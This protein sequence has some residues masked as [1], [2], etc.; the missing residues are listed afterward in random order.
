VGARFRRFGK[1]ALRVTCLVG[2]LGLTGFA[3]LASAHAAG[4]FDGTY[5]GD[6]LERPSGAIVEIVDTVITVTVTNGQLEGSIVETSIT[7][8]Q[9]VDQVLTERAVQTIDLSGTVDDAG[10]IEG[11]GR[12]RVEYEL[13]SCEPQDKCVGAHATQPGRPDGVPVSLTG[14]ITGTVLHADLVNSVSG[15]RSA[16]EATREPG[17]GEAGAPVTT[18]ID[19]KVAADAPEARLA[20]SPETSDSGIPRAVLVAVV[21]VLAGGAGVALGRVR[22]GRPRRSALEPGPAEPLGFGGAPGSAAVVV[23]MMDQ[24]LIADRG[25]ILEIWRNEGIDGLRRF[26][27]YQSGQGVTTKNPMVACGA[28]VLLGVISDPNFAGLPH[29]PP[30][31]PGDPPGQHPTPPGAP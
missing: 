26:L 12:T 15:A 23:N 25:K 5:A 29:P 27:E 9:N 11:A 6:T 31:L 28:Q 1:W 17:E 2:V 20:A 30:D 21:A 7:R 16:F 13:V 24:M 4:T 14:S 3:T 18:G 10:R 22:I 19:S 8:Q